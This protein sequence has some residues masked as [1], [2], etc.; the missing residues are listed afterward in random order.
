MYRK[1][2]ETTFTFCSFS[3]CKNRLQNENAAHI[4]YVLT[5]HVYLVNSAGTPEPTLWAVTWKVHLNRF[6]TQENFLLDN[7]YQQLSYLYFI[8]LLNESQYETVQENLK[9]KKQAY[10]FTESMRKSLFIW[11]VN[12]VNKKNRQIQNSLRS[13]TFLND[14]MSTSPTNKNTNHFDETI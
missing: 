3:T 4:I 5:S 1:E 2:L 6:D 11:M 8:Y 9:H 10:I 12:I 13:E 14:L 7:F